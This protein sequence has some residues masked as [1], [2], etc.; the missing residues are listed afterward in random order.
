MRKYR[1]IFSRLKIMFISS[2]AMFL[3]MLI[4]FSIYARMN[5]SS[6]SREIDQMKLQ[7]AQSLGP[8]IPIMKKV[9]QKYGKVDD[10]FKEGLNNAIQYVKNKDLNQLNDEVKGMENDF[11]KMM[12]DTQVKNLGKGK[13]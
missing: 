2:V 1:S 11:A 7:Y 12:K 3:S 5:G 9:I 13:K 6:L 8:S 10:N 4:V